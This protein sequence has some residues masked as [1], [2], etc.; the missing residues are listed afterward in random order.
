VGRRDVSVAQI[1]VEGVDCRLEGV[2]C[3]LEGVDCRHEGVDCRLEGVDYSRKPPSVPTPNP[4]LKP[5]PYLHIR[6]G[7][8]P[9]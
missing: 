9:R 2:D 5:C 7:D 6:G 3:R 8:K 1:G 4:C